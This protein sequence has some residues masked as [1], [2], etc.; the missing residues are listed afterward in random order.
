M[1]TVLGEHLTVSSLKQSFGIWEIF[2]EEVVSNPRAEEK[3]V[4]RQEK[5]V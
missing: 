3:T 2:L 1:N 4:I 5:G